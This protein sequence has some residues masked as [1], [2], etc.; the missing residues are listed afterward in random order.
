M[1]QYAK[2]NKSSTILNMN[3][4]NRGRDTCVCMR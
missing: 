3:N 2:R 4:P 1:N